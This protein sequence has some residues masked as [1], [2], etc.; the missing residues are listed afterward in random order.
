MTLDINLCLNRRDIYLSLLL[1]YTQSTS[2]KL[3]PPNIIFFIIII[4]RISLFSRVKYTNNKLHIHTKPC[5]AMIREKTLLIIL[6]LIYSG[7]VNYIELVLGY[8]N[9]K[10]NGCIRITGVK[11]EYYN[12]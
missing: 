1:K 3:K 5:E 4:I 12:I 7:V 8:F 11:I 2:G 10:Y 9:L 6:L